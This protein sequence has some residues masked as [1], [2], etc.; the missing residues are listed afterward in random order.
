MLNFSAAT[1]V[2]ILFTVKTYYERRQL[3]RLLCEPQMN[4][5]YPHSMHHISEWIQSVK[6][7]NSLKI[8]YPVYDMMHKH[9][10]W[11]VVNT[12]LT[13]SA[14]INSVRSILAS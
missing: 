14:T 7:S 2:R 1:S 5:G 8:L 12:L 9:P 13:T 6:L 10:V 4:K 3:P 11:T